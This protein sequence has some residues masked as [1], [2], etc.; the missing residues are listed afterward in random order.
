MP[1]TYIAQKYVDYEALVNLLASKFVAGT[2]SIKESNDQYLI[3][4]ERKLTEGE[5]V[6]VSTQNED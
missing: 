3:T 6:S 1:I 4:A 5:I 2:Y